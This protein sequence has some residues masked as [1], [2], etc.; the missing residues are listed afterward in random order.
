VLLK[1]SLA[2][3]EE[4]S[5]VSGRNYWDLRERK[6][7]REWEKK[8]SVLQV[9]WSIPKCPCI[10]ASSRFDA[11]RNFEKAAY[12]TMV[13]EPKGERKTSWESES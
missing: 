8:K 10:F 3:R 1:L 13:G 7:T 5:V 4:E 12:R 11:D 2:L 6:E 9:I